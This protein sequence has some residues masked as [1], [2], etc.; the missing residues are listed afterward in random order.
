MSKSNSN[1]IML[2]GGNI[3]FIIIHFLR[4]W[5]GNKI[6]FFKGTL[7]LS[8]MDMVYD[9]IIKDI[10]CMYVSISMLTLF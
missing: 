6:K 1:K 7:F 8:K 2:C 4:I 10:L 9:I 5:R 3:I